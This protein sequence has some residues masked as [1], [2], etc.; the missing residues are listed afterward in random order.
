M[1]IIK[2]KIQ[3]YYNTKLVKCNSYIKVCKKILKNEKI[4]IKNK[5]S[6]K[7]ST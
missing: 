3:K 6:H 1:K 5:V 4:L 7:L 2:I